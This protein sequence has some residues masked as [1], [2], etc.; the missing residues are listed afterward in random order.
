MAGE[1]LRV[2]GGPAAGT[3][4]DIATGLVLG[5]SA[6]VNGSLGGD[7]EISR[8]HAR[9][10]QGQYGGL[11]IEDLGSTNGTYV[12]G[13]RVTGQHPLNPCDTVAVGQSKLTLEAEGAGG[14]VGAL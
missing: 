4:L 10:T 9:I 6:G 1:R 14:A 13:Q 7:P 5:R 2:T 11:V 12:N 8:Q 3:T